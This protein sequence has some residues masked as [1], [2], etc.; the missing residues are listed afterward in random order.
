[1]GT[2]EIVFTASGL[3]FY[4]NQRTALLSCSFCNYKV[5]AWLRDFQNEDSVPGLMKQMEVSWKV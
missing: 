2:A 5:C 3:R 1:M 4:K